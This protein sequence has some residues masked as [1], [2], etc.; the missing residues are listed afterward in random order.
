MVNID[1]GL[2]MKAA[3][4]ARQAGNKI[5]L[6]YET[7]F[8]IEIKK[9]LSPV[10]EA[11]QVAEKII[12]DAISQKISSEFPIISE[13]AATTGQIPEIDQ[14]PFWLIDP[15][16]G[17]R[18]FIKKNGDFTVNIALLIDSQPVLGVVHLPV[19]KTTYI[20]VLGGAYRM[21]TETSA[22]TIRCR[23]PPEEGLTALVSRS[24]RTS[25]MDDYLRNFDIN[26]ELS[27]GSS[28]KFCRIAEG[29]A[30]IYPR[31]GPTMEWDTAAGHAVLKFGGGEVRTLD[32]KTLEY[33]KP[34][35]KNPHFVA[36][37]TNVLIR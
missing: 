33:G 31:L 34:G 6:I 25:D 22:E 18:E 36:A 5:M 1:F 23:V 10:T 35:F 9:D 19:H 32:G 29:T 16:D 24:H 8:A 20:G 17:T 2:A 26:Q 15:L 11:D 4:I 28:L 30:D 13:E 14:S 3:E 21:T 27:A 7:D 12:L 37:S